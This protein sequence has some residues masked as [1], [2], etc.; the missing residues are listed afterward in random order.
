MKTV[1]PPPGT[2]LTLYAGASRAYGEKRDTLLGA[3][4]TLTPQD[5]RVPFLPLVPF[6]LHWPF[7]PCIPCFNFLTTSPCPAFR[8]L[9][10]LVMRGVRTMKG[11]VKR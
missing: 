8:R 9:K 5:N 10:G 4:Q 7:L 11:T 1:G 3:G 6:G 2:I